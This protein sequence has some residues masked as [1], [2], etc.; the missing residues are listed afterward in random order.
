MNLAEYSIA[1]RYAQLLEAQKTRTLTDREAQVLAILRDC[2]ERYELEE[3]PTGRTY[4]PSM[5][6]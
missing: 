3:M 2:V 4:V 6:K 1:R 5:R